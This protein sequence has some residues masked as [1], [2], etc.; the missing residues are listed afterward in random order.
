[1]MV[2]EKK[3]TKK[4]FREFIAIEKGLMVYLDDF[5]RRYHDNG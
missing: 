4:E 5:A 2:Y 1:M 3:L